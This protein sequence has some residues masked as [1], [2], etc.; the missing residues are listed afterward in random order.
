VLGPARPIYLRRPDARVPGAP[1]R[2]TR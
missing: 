2:V 1:K